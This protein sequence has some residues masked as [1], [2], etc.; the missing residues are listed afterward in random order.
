MK[1]GLNI[2]QDAQ[3]IAYLVAGYIRKTI[4]EAEHDELDDW[5]SAS[6]HNLQLF[7]E[8]TD[9]DNIAANLAWMDG[10][11]SEASYKKLVERGAFKLQRKVRFN[12]VWLV[13]ASILLLIA[14]FIFYKY[15]AKGKK[16]RD[17]ED[18]VQVIQPG[19]NK[20][21][22]TLGDGTKVDLN[23]LRVG[24]IE[25]PDNITIHKTDNGTL[26]YE[27]NGKPGNFVQHTLSTP[28]G[29]QYKVT[30]PDGTNVWLN[31]ASSLRYPSRFN[32]SERVVT[33]TGEAYFEVAK[34]AKKSFYVFV[35]DLAVEVHGTH[36]N[37]NGYIDEPSVVTT[38]LEG[39]VEVLKNE[40]SKIL[41][42]GEQVTV[43]GNRFTVANADTAA[44]VAWKNKIFKFV[45]APIDVVMRQVQRWYNA[46]VIYQ[47][48]VTGHFN[49]TL[50]RSEPIEKLLH[51][52]EA[53]GQ[54][55]F[56]IKN[57]KII[58]MK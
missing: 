10:V 7:E 27:E 23:G 16:P 54:V 26:Y 57:D 31:A 19:S 44:V 9:E 34:D 21:T 32:D 15:T 45:N 49:A 46:E 55:H 1:E 41:S 50:D 40:S 11:D 14:A 30:L 2:P 48:N 39:S 20:A 29:G 52:L 35:D 38:L 12:K 3:R 18:T 53:T 43:R 4:T 58:I 47:D 8:L 37:V 56:K 25:N 36:F 24:V 42:P 13:A 5:I 17:K 22:L 28:V 6:D 51:Y 33:L